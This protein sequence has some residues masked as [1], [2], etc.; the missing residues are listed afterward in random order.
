MKHYSDYVIALDVGG[1]NMRAAL[2]T[3]RGRI[4][5]STRE[6]TKS[7]GSRKEVIDQI[8]RLVSQ[9]SEHSKHRVSAVGIGFPGPLN[10]EEGFILSPPNLPAL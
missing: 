4:L 10:A 9:C 8:A 5:F 7:T 1:T 6:P 2:V 3:G